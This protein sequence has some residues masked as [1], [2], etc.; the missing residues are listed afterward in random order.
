MHNKTSHAAIAGAAA[1]LILICT[2]AVAQTPRQLTAQDYAAA[3]KFMP[4]NA[5]PLAY[6]GLVRA[7]ILDDGRFWYRAVDEKGIS[8]VLMDPAKATRTPM[9]DAA[10][11]AALLK[12]ATRGGFHSDARRLIVSDLSLSDD[13]RVLTLTAQHVIYRCELGSKPE[14]CKAVSDEHHWP[15]DSGS[16][17]PMSL[18]PNKKLGAFIRDW[19]LWVRDL[20]TGAETQLTTDGVKDFGYA[21][22][23][24]GWKAT[25]AAILLWS[26]DSTRDRDLP[27][28]PAQ[29]R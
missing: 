8:Y 19:N 11:V 22:D 14:S 28:G 10:K 24:A 21:T 17:P 3:E 12:E 4:Y 23:N 18:S 1:A 7:Q 2:A 27:A 25:D 9:F 6:K 26:P 29:D 13:D 15:L 20:A 16:H 5:N